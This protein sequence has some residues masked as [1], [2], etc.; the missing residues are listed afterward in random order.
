MALLPFL[1]IIGQLLDRVLPDPAVAA[2][3]KLELE[4]QVLNGELE[5][6]LAQL[7]INKVEAASTSL[8]VAGWRP[9]IGWVCGSALAYTYMLQPF[10]VFAA[11][12]LGR[13][14]SIPTLSLSDLMP[15][16]FALLGLGTMRSYE[17]VKGARAPVG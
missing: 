13:S 5:A 16:L 17:I 8:F 7:D 11:T 2:A 4:K 12:A 10:L 6:V 1:P 9:F 14:V 15:V 3:A